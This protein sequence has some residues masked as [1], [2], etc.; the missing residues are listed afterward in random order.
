MIQFGY[1]FIVKDDDN[2]ECFVHYK[3]LNCGESKFKSVENGSKV[4]FEIQRK[5]EGKLVAFNVTGPG[6]IPVEQNPL[7][8]LKN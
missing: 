7:Q 4:E 2:S 6:G 3:N 5:T 8:Q 1:G